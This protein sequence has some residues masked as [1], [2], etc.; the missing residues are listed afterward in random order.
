LPAKTPPI[1]HPTAKVLFVTTFTDLI[2]AEF[3]GKY[4][5][6]LRLVNPPS[7]LSTFP[8]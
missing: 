6:T 2:V 8:P 7:T 4:E 5:S 3:G 1:L